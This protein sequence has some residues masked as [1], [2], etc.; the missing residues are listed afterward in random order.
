[1]DNKISE[2]NDMEGVKELTRFHEKQLPKTFTIDRHCVGLGGRNTSLE[3][4][5]SAKLNS[6]RPFVLT[7]VLENNEIEMKTKGKWKTHVYREL[8]INL[9]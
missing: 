8:E 2:G 7:P 3:E 6:N 9:T 4:D 1:M 5:R